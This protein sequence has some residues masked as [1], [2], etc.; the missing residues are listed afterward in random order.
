MSTIPNSVLFRII[1]IIVVVVVVVVVVIV[2]FSTYF[3]ALTI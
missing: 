3:P 2:P 1:I